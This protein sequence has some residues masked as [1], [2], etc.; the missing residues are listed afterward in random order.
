VWEDRGFESTEA[1]NE[2]LIERFNSVVQE[3]DDVYILGD[4]CMGSDLLGN[5]SLIERLNGRLH[6]VIGNHDTDN[7]I[8]MFHACKNVVEFC[9]YATVLKY[10]KYRFYLSHYPTNTANYDADE[11]L[12]ARTINL[13][14]HT[15]STDPLCDFKEGYLRYHVEV[16]GHNCY[17]VP[18]DSIIEA[19]HPAHE[20]HCTCNGNCGENCKCKK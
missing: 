13:C 8:G 7:R 5:K 15:H 14:G 20:H 16:D 19:L 9:G 10:K 2:G 6:I 17:P 11:P 18:L 1:M 12:K 4:L 3:E